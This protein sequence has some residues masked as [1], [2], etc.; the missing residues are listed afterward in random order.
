MGAAAIAGVAGAI[1]L[2][3]LASSDSVDNSNDNAALDQAKL[4]V[5]SLQGELDSLKSKLASA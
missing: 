5:Q 1:G 3:A 4:E 2:G